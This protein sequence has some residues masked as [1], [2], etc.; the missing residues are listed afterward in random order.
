M[1]ALVLVLVAILPGGLVG[2]AAILA[3]LGKERWRRDSEF[4][5]SYSIIPTLGVVWLS[6]HLTSLP[7]PPV[8]APVHF[9][10]ELFCGLTGGFMHFWIMLKCLKQ[11]WGEPDER[12]PWWPPVVWWVQLLL[13]GALSY[14]LLGTTL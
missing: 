5:L 1:K 8:I 14:Y 10:L 2:S 4:I 11:Y 13:F 7:I 3:L 9:E 6:T 12:I